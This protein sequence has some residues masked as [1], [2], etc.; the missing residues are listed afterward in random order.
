MKVQRLAQ[1]L[2]ERLDDEQEPTAAL[3]QV[4]N[5]LLTV[6]RGELDRL[7]G[8]ARRTSADAATAGCILRRLAVIE[9]LRD[10]T[11]AVDDAA[12]TSEMGV[13]ETGLPAAPPSSSR[14]RP[15]TTPSSPSSKAGAAG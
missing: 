1:Q 3:P 12:I 13:L 2:D 7:A 5:E 15:T 10:H 4:V 14:S 6:T 8:M 9:A 11:A